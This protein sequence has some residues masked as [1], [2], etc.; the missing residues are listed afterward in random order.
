MPWVFLRCSN[1]S[2]CAVSCQSHVARAVPQPCSLLAPLCWG[3]FAELWGASTACWE[4]K[5]PCPGFGFGE[6]PSLPYHQPLHLGVA[7]QA[8]PK[9]GWI[10]ACRVSCLSRATSTEGLWGTGL[11]CGWKKEQRHPFLVRAFCLDLAITCNFILDGF[12]LDLP[13]V[14]VGCCHKSLCDLIIA[15]D[16]VHGEE[17]TY[18][19]WYLETGI[20]AK[21]MGTM[22]ELPF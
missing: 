7:T 11:G 13:L 18:P 5:G 20:Q 17:G 2:C 19:C 16:V 10:F 22:C 21:L 12:F 9:S 6:R 1:L 8:W 3:L 14:S 15:F 4:P